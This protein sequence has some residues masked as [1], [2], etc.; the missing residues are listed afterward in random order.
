VRGSGVRVVVEGDACGEGEKALC[1]ADFEALEGSCAVAFE[2]EDVFAGP[3]DRLD[4]LADRGE[5]NPGPGFVFA[6][7]SDD[8][9]AQFADPGLELASGVALVAEDCLSARDSICR[10]TSR[11][12]RLGEVSWRALGGAVGCEQ[13]VQETPK[14]TAGARRSSRSQQ[15]RPRPSGESFRPIGATRSGWNR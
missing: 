12:P 3:K 4:A 1:D 6:G 13:A 2:G 10:A 11:S 14:T 7:W 9:G 15:P 8:R 5:V